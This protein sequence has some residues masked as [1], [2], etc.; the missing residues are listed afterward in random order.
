MPKR[1]SCLH[2]VLLKRRGERSPPSPG[3][4]DRLA[5][6][7]AAARFRHPLDYLCFSSLNYKSHVLAGENRVGKELLRVSFDFREKGVV[8]VRV[9]VG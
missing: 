2:F 5:W 9:V 6:F 4:Q 8:M 3:G 1:I 7:T